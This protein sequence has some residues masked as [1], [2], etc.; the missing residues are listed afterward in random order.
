MWKNLSLRTKFAVSF[1]AIIVL[2]LFSAIWAIF[3]IGGI[4]VDAEEVIEGNKLKADIEVKYIQHLKWAQEVSN[5]FTND[6]VTKLEV[7]KNP[8]QC[9]FGKW[10]YGEQRK[11]VQT[12][13]PE[14]AHILE[15]MDEPHAKLHASAEKIG[16]AYCQFDMNS[17][18]VLKQCKIDH[19]IWVN[20]VK[21]ALFIDNSRK[22]PVVKDH[23]KCK[24]GEWLNSAEMDEFRNQHPEIESELEPLISKHSIL[25]KG[26]ITLENLQRVNKNQEAKIYFKN[27]IEKNTNKVIQQLETLSTYVENNMAG[28]QEANKIYHD[29]TLRHLD[30]LGML[31]TELIQESDKHILSDKEMLVHASETRFGVI[32]IALI[33]VLISISLAVIITRGILKP[34]IKSVHFANEIAEGNLDA[35]INI[36]QN[37]EIG[38]LAKSLKSMSEKLTEI[39]I[40]IKNSSNY[41][42]GASQEMSSTS[43][44][45]S[46]SSNEQAASVEEITSTME[47]MSANIAQSSENASQTDKISAVAYQGMLETKEGTNRAVKAN[48][49]IS[50][51]IKIINDIAFQTNILALNAAVEA[52]RAGEHGKGFAVVAVEVRKLA[53][54]CK[55]AAEDIVSL[56]KNCYDITQDARDKLE[57]MLPELEKTT[58]LI[59]EISASSNEQNNGANQVSDSMQQLNNATQQNASASEEL[60]TSSEELAA[61][62]M[63]LKELITFFRTNKSHSDIGK[64]LLDAHLHKSDAKEKSNTENTLPVSPSP[65][66][67]EFDT[68][69]F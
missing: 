21:E 47:E 19:I 20:K 16:E 48:K 35:N 28:T 67:T 52:A 38:K 15:K 25:H 10:Y 4:L 43:Q 50:E 7:Q 9:E 61:Q 45:L 64:N 39:V 57:E 6:T 12:W 56:A 62:A 36:N 33:V 1:G 59:Q 66:Q 55:F 14:F 23:K 41:I 69:K 5:L 11:A 13:I 31:F 60:A 53:E 29:E 44:Q 22:I 63:Y 58:R 68:D 3:G 37:D 46:H 8:K 49:E 2:L 54:R 32:L 34:I 18:I 65:A 40:N 24:L 26:A 27:T 17:A 51:K 30:E 42:A